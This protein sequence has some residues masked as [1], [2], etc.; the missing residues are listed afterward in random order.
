MAKKTGTKEWAETS[1]NIARGCSHGCRYCYV[2]HNLVCR[3]K[4]ITPEAWATPT[5]QQD[6]VDAKYGKMTG[7]I[8]FPTAHDI[9]PEILGDYCKVLEKLLVAG[10]SVL[11]VTK[12]H[13]ECVDRICNQFAEFKDQ[14]LFRFTIGSIHEDVLKFWEPGA[15]G[16]Q[17]RMECLKFSHHCGFQTSVSCEPFLDNDTFQLYRACRPYIT[18]SFWVGLLRHWNTRVMISDVPSDD[19]AKYV[20]PLSRLQLLPN[21]RILY[22][23]MK[24]SK[25]VEWKDSI[26]ELM[27]K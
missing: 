26:R 20:I 21:V 12:P 19:F 15:P 10:N 3:F 7:T 24:E 8:M 1:L 18:E 13:I 6:S 22:E 16:A 2:R 17:E 25:K 4:K 14:L 11:I 23:S 5:I 27:E 9:Q